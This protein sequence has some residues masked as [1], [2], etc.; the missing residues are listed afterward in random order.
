MGPRPGGAC[1]HRLLRP[2]PASPSKKRPCSSWQHLFFT[3][4]GAE[5]GSWEP[6]RPCL[7][8]TAERHSPGSGLWPCAHPGLPGWGAGPGSALLPP[9]RPHN[10]PGLR[11][12][13]AASL[14]SVGIAGGGHGGARDRRSTR[15]LAGAVEGSSPPP[16][17]CNVRSAH[18]SHSQGLFTV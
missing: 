15:K 13:S 2:P 7:R 10:P 8:N 4:S 12:G 6:P 11:E 17:P 3:V 1:Q 5:R 16:C 9:S 14:S 18:Y